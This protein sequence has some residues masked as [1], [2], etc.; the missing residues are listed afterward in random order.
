M[1]ESNRKFIEEWIIEHVPE[2]A[3]VLDVGCGDGALLERLVKEKGAR[4]TGIEIEEANV[5]KAIQRGLSVHHGDAEEGLDH[6]ADDKFDVVIFS[7]TIQ[8]LGH[9]Q[10]LLREAF[11]VGKQLIVTF[12]NFGHWQARWQLGILG[13]APSTPCLPYT[14]FETPNRHYLTVLDW[15]TF[16]RDEGWRIL[17]KGFVSCGRPVRFFPNLRAEAAMYLLEEIAPSPIQNH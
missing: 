8:E 13:R 12:P 7:L 1:R 2:R 3:R 4:G 6:Y 11:R 16:A 17:D 15:E 9:P 10:R 5:R 14:W